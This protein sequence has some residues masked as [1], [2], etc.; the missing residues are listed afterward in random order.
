VQDQS[1]AQAF[2]ERLA[3]QPGGPWYL[4]GSQYEPD[5]QVV[6]LADIDPHHPWGEP[7]SF[8]SFVDRT[9]YRQLLRCFIGGN[10]QDKYRSWSLDALQQRTSLSTEELEEALAFC[11]QQD[12]AV[13]DE[14][15]AQRELIFRF[16][17]EHALAEGKPPFEP[18]PE[19]LE[20]LRLLPEKPAKWYS[21]SRLDFI[22][23]SGPTLEWTIQTILEREFHAL[24]RR[25]VKV[26][27]FF[28]LGDI[29]VLAF[30]PD[31][32]SVL[33]ECKSSTKNITDG[34]VQRFLQKVRRFQPD[35]AV[36]LVDTADHQQFEQRLPQMLRVLFREY[37]EVTP[38]ERPRNLGIT[39]LFRLQPTVFFAISGIRL[40]ATF[41]FLLYYERYQLG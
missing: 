31:Q 5:D 38:S 14:T 11:H 29:D 26:S 24:A 28:F 23:N 22:R 10:S 8:L 1:N 6:Q 40:S 30:L 27:P 4:N 18:T 37:R 19:D 20:K 9:A 32:R 16:L 41:H 25:N 34:H 35:V 21:N 7:H 39:S 17:R 3:L 12:F 13:P 2:V 36:F 33:V 15:R